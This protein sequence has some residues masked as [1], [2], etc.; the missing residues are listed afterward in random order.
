[1]NGLALRGTC[2]SFLAGSVE[3][4]LNMCCGEA[5]KAAP[6]ALTKQLRA[7][8]RVELFCVLVACLRAGKAVSR[9]IAA[10]LFIQANCLRK[11]F[12]ILLPL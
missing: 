6:E 4:V 3:M 1:M 8:P 11:W 2:S 9:L 10:C 5:A 7:L 12:P